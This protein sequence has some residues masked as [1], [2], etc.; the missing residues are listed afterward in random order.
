LTYSL[1]SDIVLEKLSKGDNYMNGR[2]V[3]QKYHKLFVANFENMTVDEAKSIFYFL[4]QSNEWK[5]KITPD[6]DLTTTEIN[7]MKSNEG[8]CFNVSYSYGDFLRELLAKKAF[9]TIHFDETS[10]LYRISMLVNK[11]ELLLHTEKEYLVTEE[12]GFINSNLVRKT[13]I[14]DNVSEEI[15]KAN[16]DDVTDLKVYANNQFEDNT[17]SD[18]KNHRY[19]LNMKR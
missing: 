12:Y 15:V 18:L 19:N 14:C 5:E 4:V 7:L 3:L 6:E 2:L 1:F 17:F 9:G 10:N 13:M 11:K 16:L 8:Y